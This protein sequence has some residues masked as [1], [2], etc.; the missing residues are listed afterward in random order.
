MAEHYG[1]V[2]KKF[3]KEWWPYYWMYYKWHTIGVV[4][5]LVL[6]IVTLVQCATSEKYDVIVNYIGE[7]Y[8]EPETA[9]DLEAALGSLIEDVDGN[10]ENNVFFQQLTL[11]NTA[12]SEELD[13][14]LQMKHDVGLTDDTSYLYMYDKD[15]AELM[16]GRESADDVYLPV[17]EW[18]DTIDIEA[19][20]GS[21]TVLY[22]ESGTPLAVL[23]QGSGFLESV[24]MDTTGLYIT[25]RRNYSDE[26]INIAAYRSAVAMANAILK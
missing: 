4:F 26:E 9:E 11:N 21:D 22:S 20:E 10:G 6:I 2:P 24:G 16:L 12:G 23:A 1:V 5:A 17:G 7:T 25:V 13:Y 3:T 8:F 14:T 18:C 19:A 15:E